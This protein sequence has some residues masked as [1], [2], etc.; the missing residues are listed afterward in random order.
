MRA[1]S[2]Y[3]TRSKQ[4]AFTLIELLVVISIIALLISI[5]LPSLAKAKELADRAVCSANIRSII[6]SMTIYAQDSHGVFPCAVGPYSTYINDAAMPQVSTPY[7]GLTSS[8]G[9]IA[10][11]WLN[12]ANADGTG[13]SPLGSLWL[14]VLTG[15][16]PPK[17]FICPS[18]PIAT[19]PSLLYTSTIPN[20]FPNFGYLSNSATTPSTSGQ[21]ESYSIAYPWLYNSAGNVMENAGNWW[22]NDSSTDVPIACDMAPQSNTGSGVFQRATTIAATA[23]TYGD[24]IFNSGNHTG[25]GQ[26]VGFADDHVVW[27]TSP[28]VGQQGDNIFT[29]N[30]SVPSGAGTPVTTTGLIGQTIEVSTITAPYDTCMVPVRNVDNGNW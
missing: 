18:D 9:T 24:Y 15:Q 21:G 10:N 26:N 17:I 6:Q 1:T 11:Y 19:E 28:Y 30:P 16:D 22:V 20:C 8:A 5:L 14:L 23:N 3:L 25:D 29:Y 7:P 2:K 12:T 13:G 4:R 27:E